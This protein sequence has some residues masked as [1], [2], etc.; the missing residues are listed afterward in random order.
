VKKPDEILL[1]AI[2]S[3]SNN[4]NFNIFMSW[5]SDTLEEHK[6]ALVDKAEDRISGMAFELRTICQTVAG[7][8]GKL[9]SMENLQSR[10]RPS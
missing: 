7:A 8:R 5:L 4:N 9:N 10:T 3:L 2:L 1:K 6:D